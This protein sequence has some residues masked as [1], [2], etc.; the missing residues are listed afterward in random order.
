MYN[1]LPYIEESTLYKGQQGLTGTALQ[2]AAMT[3]GQT[4]LNAFYCPSRRP[5]QAYPTWP[6]RPIRH[7]LPPCRFGLTGDGIDHLRSE[8]TDDQNL[9]HR[10]DRRSPQRLCR[11]FL[12]LDR[13]G[14]EYRSLTQRRSCTGPDNFENQRSWRGGNAY[15]GVR[16]HG[17]RQGL[18]REHELR[19]RGRHSPVYNV[20]VA[21]VSDGT[22]NIILCG[23]KYVDPNQYFTESSTAMN[24]GS[25]WRL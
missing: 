4:P 15:A 3:L 8:P 18:G 5:A 7:R 6:R 2:A 25:P 23:E 1:I 19:P 24:G 9:G 22:S 16:H 12:Q 20:T 14:P 13:T 11:Q 10:H 17:K 21:Q